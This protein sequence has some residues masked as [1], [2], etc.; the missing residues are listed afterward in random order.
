MVSYEEFRSMLE[1]AIDAQPDYCFRNLNGGILLEEETK[2]SPAARNND[3]FILG[4]YFRDRVM[5]R[6]VVLYYGSFCRVYGG[7]PPEQMAERIRHVLRHELTH[8][9][10]SLAG[11]R[12]LE[13]EDALFLARYQQK[14]ENQEK[15]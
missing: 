6:H 4:Q 3:L 8:H 14:F 11:D 10:E 5:G 12:S 13:E 1:D 15:T 7:L 2:V 9:V